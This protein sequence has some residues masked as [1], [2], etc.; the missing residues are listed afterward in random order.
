MKEVLNM[1]LNISEVQNIAYRL[2]FETVKVLEKNNI[3][4]Y[5]VYGTL[6][7]AYRHT[8]F[9]P[10]DSDI[11]IAVPQN[12]LLKLV[13]VCRKELPADLCVDYFI[14]DSKSNCQFPRISLKGYFSENVHVDV[15]PIIGVPD[16][17]NEILDFMEEIK[18]E[19]DMHRLCSIWF[20]YAALQFIKGNSKPL[21][22]KIK[23]LF[24][25]KHLHARRYFD[26]CNKYDYDTA[27]KVI[28]AHAE[29]V[30]P[31]DIYEKYYFGNGHKMLFGDYYF[32]CPDESEL[33]LERE[34]GDWKKLPPEEEIFKALKT[35]FIIRKKL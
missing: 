9:I 6:I 32:N 19:A 1:K 2:L 20:P 34:Y 35:I 23:Y 7:G 15:F 14:G 22:N 13:E 30:K 33:L 27:N 31:R 28:I 12:E 4:Y 5:I 24:I 21:L 17:E 29:W 25:P 16:N 3:T 26:L 10:W 18:N 11:D 8:N